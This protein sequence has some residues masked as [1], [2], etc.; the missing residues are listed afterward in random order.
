MLV[1]I[2]TFGLS[3]DPIMFCIMLVFIP[4]FDLSSD[5]MMFCI[6]RK[7]EDGWRK[8]YEENENCS[9]MPIL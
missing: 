1:Y 2:P 6:R 4:T 9:R 8:G 5:P 7:E 3:S